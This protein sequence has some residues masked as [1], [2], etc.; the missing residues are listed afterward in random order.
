MQSK[1]EMRDGGYILCWRNTKLNLK[2]D[3]KMKDA[4]QRGVIRHF[5]PSCLDN[6]PFP[7]RV[8][9]GGGGGMGGQYTK[10][11]M[12][13]LSKQWNV[14]HRKEKR[15]K[16]N[17]NKNNSTFLISPELGCPSLC[18]CYDNSSCPLSSFGSISKLRTMT[19]K[20]SESEEST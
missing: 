15:Q 20:R 16:E 7:L 2:R 18:S 5:L 11:A 4:F 6:S 1:R 3:D 12:S 17:P 10:M 14:F 9:G 8:A 19:V 13:A